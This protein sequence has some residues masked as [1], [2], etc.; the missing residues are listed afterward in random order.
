[1]LR[2]RTSLA[3]SGSG[4]RTVNVTWARGS[5]VAVGPA[6]GFGVEGL[7]VGKV[8][9]LS[10]E[11]AQAWLVMARMIM[12]NRMRREKIECG[13]IHSPRC[14]MLGW[15]HGAVVPPA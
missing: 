13:F 15:A 10:S 7:A 14:F 6:A 4:R 5:A 8:G 3:D 9:H 11:M 12:K 1:M 2:A